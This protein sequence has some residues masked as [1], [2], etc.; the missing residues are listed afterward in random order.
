MG[1]FHRVFLRA[2]SKFP[3]KDEKGLFS[4]CSESLG[5]P[6]PAQFIGGQEHQTPE[7]R[8]SQK[9]S[10]LYKYVRAKLTDFYHANRTLKLANLAEKAFNW[11]TSGLW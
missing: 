9:V 8:S 10:L 5:S 11:Q 1:A 4:R 7:G 6:R 2:F 3:N